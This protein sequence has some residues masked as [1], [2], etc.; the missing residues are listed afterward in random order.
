MKQAVIRLLAITFVAMLLGGFSGGC[1]KKPVMPPT[2]GAGSADIT[3]KDISYPAAE[4]GYSEGS[5][6]REGTLDDSAAG[7]MGVD[8]IQD[9]QSAEYKQLHGRTSPG[10]LPVYF[11]FDQAAIKPDMAERLIQNGEYLKQMTNSVVI[12]GNCDD[13]GTN[14]YNLALGEKRAINVRSYLLNLGISP[15]R[16]RTVSYGEERPLFTEQTEF[17]WSQNRRVDFVVE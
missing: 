6:S 1:T 14:E 7:S 4:G 16:I 17:A 11:D 15:S 2:G 8:G 3:G 13:R 9:K 10:M 5:L 12:E